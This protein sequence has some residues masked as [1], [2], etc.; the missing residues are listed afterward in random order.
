MLPSVKVA[1]M[2]PLVLTKLTVGLKIQV[3]GPVSSDASCLHCDCHG[4]TKS[5]LKKF[6]IASQFEAWN[7]LNIFFFHFRFI[8]GHESHFK[9]LAIIYTVCHY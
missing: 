3:S 4:Y 7:S 6:A 1:Q 5:H 2:I 9:A 8:S